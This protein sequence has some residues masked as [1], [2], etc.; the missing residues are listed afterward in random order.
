MVQAFQAVADGKVKSIHLINMIRFKRPPAVCPVAAVMT[1]ACRIC[2]PDGDRWRFFNNV[3][4]P[5]SVRHAMMHR[6]GRKKKM[7]KFLKKILSVQK[8]F[9]IL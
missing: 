5:H 9:V 4:L 6:V 2:H 1:N 8:K 7:M 3:G